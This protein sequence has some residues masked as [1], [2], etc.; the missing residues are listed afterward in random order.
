MDAA[1]IESR[2]E[3]ALTER[4]RPMLKSHGGGIAIR[5][6]DHHGVVRLDWLGA[7]TG[8]PLRPVTTAGLIEPELTRIEGVTGVDTGFRVSRAAAERLRRVHLG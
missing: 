8:C 7:C 5:E 1:A 4:L 2:V 3:D 6:I